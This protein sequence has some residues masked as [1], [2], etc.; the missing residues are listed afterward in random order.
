MFSLLQTFSSC[1]DL[2]LLPSC[3]VWPSRCGDF[4]LQSMGSMAHEFQ[5][6]Q[7]L[8]SVVVA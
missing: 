7:L 5:H 1:S 2:G 3:G 4:S 6:L 8:G